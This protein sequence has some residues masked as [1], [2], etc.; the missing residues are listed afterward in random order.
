MTWEANRLEA[1]LK[2][3]PDLLPDEDEAPPRGR[4]EP[5]PS[6]PPGGERGPDAGPEE[7]GGGPTDVEGASGAG[8]PPTSMPLHQVGEGY[9]LSVMVPAEFDTRIS[10]ILAGLRWEDGRKVGKVEVVRALILVAFDLVRWGDLVWDDL[11]GLA[12]QIRRHLTSGGQPH[13]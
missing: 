5:A 7:A 11:E 9:K 3:L 8:R 12:W 4:P 6:R 1:R 2:S 13:G 10:T